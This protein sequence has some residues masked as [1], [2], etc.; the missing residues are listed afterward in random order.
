[1][2]PDN[3]NTPSP[4]PPPPVTPPSTATPISASAPTLGAILGAVAAAKVVGLAA[5][6][7]VP[8]LGVILGPLIVGTVTAAFH[9]LGNKF[10]IPELG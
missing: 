10:R 1:M 5:I 2:E 9:W 3:V 8:G 4:V 6:A 7:A